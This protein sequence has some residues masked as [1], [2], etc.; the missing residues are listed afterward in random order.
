MGPGEPR[1]AWQT[2]WWGSPIPASMAPT[3]SH[4]TTPDPIPIHWDACKT[5]G[6]LTFL[7]LI[8]PPTPFSTSPHSPHFTSNSFSRLLPFYLQLHLI[9]CCCRGRGAACWFLQGLH[10]RLPTLPTQGR[11]RLLAPCSHLCSPDPLV[12][13]HSCAA[14]ASIKL[15]LQL[16]QTSSNFK[17]T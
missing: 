3:A 5:F 9:S 7:K 8:S 17:M 13:G 4:P 12:A 1:A 6:P 15:S 14:Q 11:D 16:I 2:L 10:G